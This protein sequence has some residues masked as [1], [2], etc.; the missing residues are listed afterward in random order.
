M[1]VR[2]KLHRA[3]VCKTNTYSRDREAVDHMVN[4]KEQGIHAEHM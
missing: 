2:N 3:S 4:K 1:L